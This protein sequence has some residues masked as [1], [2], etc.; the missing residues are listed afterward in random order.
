[1][2]DCIERIF[3][4]DLAELVEVADVNFM[5]LIARVFKVR[6]NI[7]ELDFWRIII[8]EIIYHN[9]AGVGCGKQTIYEMAA[10]KACSAGY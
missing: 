5:Q 8:A 6:A 1:M 3:S 10:N 9:D 7:G 2:N 4:D